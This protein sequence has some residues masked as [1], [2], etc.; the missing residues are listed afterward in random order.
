[1]KIIHRGKFNKCNCREIC[2]C[3]SKEEREE[4][5][6]FNFKQYRKMI[7]GYELALFG[8]CDLKA[9]FGALE[10]CFC[11]YFMYFYI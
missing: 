3:I 6:I 5:P 1:M 2:I 9:R 10:A 8:L 4:T 11:K 7:A